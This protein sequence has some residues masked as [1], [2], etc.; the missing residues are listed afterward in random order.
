MSFDIELYQFYA[1]FDIGEI[2]TMIENCPLCFVELKIT[3][4]NKF[5]NYLCKNPECSRIAFNYDN[6]IIVISIRLEYRDEKYLI[7]IRKT[8]L[9]VDKLQLDGYSQQKS[10][11]GNYLSYIDFSNLEQSVQNLLDRLINLTSYQ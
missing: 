10:F 1:N 7:T 9:C 6:D 11:E 5:D 2:K 3:P 4:F 8:N